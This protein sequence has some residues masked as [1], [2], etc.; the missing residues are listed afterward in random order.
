MQ[1][2]AVGNENTVVNSGSEEYL[3]GPSKADKRGSK[4]ICFSTNGVLTDDF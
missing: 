1:A 2:Q 4:G 3:I